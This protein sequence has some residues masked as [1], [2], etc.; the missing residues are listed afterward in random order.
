M[1]TT[2]LLGITEIYYVT[3]N[4]AKFEEASEFFKKYVP[5]ITLKQCDIGGY[6]IQ[7]LDQ[8][9]IAIDKAQQAWQEI[10][11]PLLVDDVGV[12]FDTYPQFPGTMTKFV[13]QSLGL[14]GLFKL[15]DNGERMHIKIVVVF[16]Y[17]N[18]KYLVIED[19]VYGTF[20]KEH[21]LDLH[22]TDAPFDTVFIPDGATQT[23]DELRLEGKAEQYR[24]RIRALKKFFGIPL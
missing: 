9:A 8:T 5:H 7:T 13:Y 1:S 21:R 16:M 22:R 20:E 23:I 17:A 10:K 15:I 12:Y 11:K 6:E 4:A 24:Y 3:G 2:L 18:N 19:V 14:K